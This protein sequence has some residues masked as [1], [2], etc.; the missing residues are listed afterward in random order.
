V[1]ERDH[2]LMPGSFGGDGQLLTRL[3]ENSDPGL[4]ALGDEAIKTRVPAFTRDED[5]VKAALPGL[6]SF[7]HRVQAVENFH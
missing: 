6:E 5:V 7:F 4:A 3:L 2:T 1:N